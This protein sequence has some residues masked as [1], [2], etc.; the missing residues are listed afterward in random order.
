VRRRQDIGVALQAVPVYRLEVGGAIFLGIYLVGMAFILSLQNR[1][2]TEFGSGAVRA[3]NLTD[4]P[5]ALLKQERVLSVLL[6]AIA[7]IGDSGD[8]RE[9]G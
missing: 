9:G 4:L 8:E 2:F 7:E 3:R 1:A 5:D 6:N